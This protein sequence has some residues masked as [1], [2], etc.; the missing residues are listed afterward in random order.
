MIF[1]GGRAIAVCFRIAT[2]SS[3]DLD[4]E[5]TAREDAVHAAFRETLR[6]VDFTRYVT[7]CERLLLGTL[8]LISSILFMAFFVCR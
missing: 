2:P 7:Y 6:T 4:T 8:L 5:A 3:S 1:V